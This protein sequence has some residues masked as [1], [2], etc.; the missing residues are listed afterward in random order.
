MLNVRRFLVFSGLI[1]LVLLFQN[2]MDF[3]PM[4]DFSSPAEELFESSATR[5]VTT[6]ALNN[7][8]KIEMDT[9]APQAIR[10]LSNLEYEN[11]LHDLLD[12]V[13]Y[14]LYYNVFHPQADPNF[15]LLPDESVTD[16]ISIYLRYSNT[17]TT[18]SVD[19]LNV[20][21]LIATQ[22]SQQMIATDPGYVRPILDMCWNG[23]STTDACLTTIATNF[24]ARAFRHPLSADQLADAQSAMTGSSPTAKLS[25]LVYYFL[26]SPDFLYHMEADGQLNGD[27][28]TLDQYA[29][30]SRI[31]YLLVATMPDATL[32]AKAAAG[33][34]GD[35][36]GVE[37]AIDYLRATYPQ[38]VKDRFWQF[39][40]EWL[41]PPSVGFSVTAPLIAEAAPTFD[42]Y[43]NSNQVRAAM[44]TDIR[45]MF[46]YYVFTSNGSYNDLFT[47]Q[48]SFTTD[49]TVAALYGT[50]AWDG[51]S[52][53]P[54]MPAN[55]RA[56]FMTT[57]DM[58]TIGGSL[59]N[60][61]RTGG[62]FHKHVI[63]R[64]FGNT[65]DPN[66]LPAPSE[67][68]GQL[69]ST[70]EL[71]E[72]LVP[73]N[74]GCMACH[75]G[76]EAVGMPFQD[77]DAL[78]RHRHGTETVYKSDGTVEGTVPVNA[79]ATPFINNQTANVPG[80]VQM[81]HQFALSTEPE[82]CFA[83]QYFRFANARMENAQDTCV[84]S[85]FSQKLTTGSVWDSIKEMVGDQWFLKRKL[86]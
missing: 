59:T 73:R 16:G 77:Y 38:K 69:T 13:P 46:E 78:G 85:R 15:I 10:P 62:T 4:R 48:K 5:A 75:A 26:M 35:R 39:V 40:T 36:A 79:N 72:Q 21:H 66:M 19:R 14:N 86:D 58:L 70:R 44:Q 57:A 37:A 20:Y 6:Q 29:V 63:C 17:S 68:D 24:G 50:T 76:V 81:I 43:N 34:L 28:L 56:G 52:A 11:S 2:C 1:G 3:V 53:P 61:F 7:A 83:R 84:L 27:V 30:A 42:A 31:S 74:S 33:Q 82:A 47:N 9:V 54:D 49:A 67:V 65:P 8:C 71:F 22:I 12:W 60:P 32:M 41:R 25:N 45:N 80:A 55:E 64:Q 51:T 23:D 18:M